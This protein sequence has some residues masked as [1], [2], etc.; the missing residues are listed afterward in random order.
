MKTY[1]EKLKDPRWQRK[2]LEVME[3][4]DFSCE[5]CGSKEK[6]LNVHHK[7]Y[8]KGADPWEY[9]ETELECLC[10]GCHASNHEWRDRINRA[11]AMG[12]AMELEY[13]AGYAEAI[14]WFHFG[15]DLSA[16]IEIHS[17]EH[18]AGIAAAFNNIDVE[19]VLGLL[20]T[21]NRVAVK[22]LFDIYD[23]DKA[24]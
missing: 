22:K 12:G 11:L 14:Y 8:R 24:E 10:E 16:S 13:V 2:R 15:P 1:W 5:C 4:A 20:D 19:K 17:W 21:N 7:I 23:Q 18:A 3:R 6:T 9:D